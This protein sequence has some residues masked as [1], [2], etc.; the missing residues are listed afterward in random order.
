M[1]TAI[2]PHLIQLLTRL[3]GSA[4]PELDASVSALCEALEQGHVCLP[5]EKVLG[6]HQ[7]RASSVV[8][9]PG[10]LRPLI[11]D[12]VGRLYL[13]RYW[14]HENR[15][16]LDLLGRAASRPVFDDA[17][18]ES[19]IK[20]FLADGDPLQRSAVRN[21]V[22]RNFS[23]ITGGP[24]TG[25]TY[26]AT[27]ALALLAAQF[28]ASG[29]RARIVIA[30]PTGKAAARIRESLKTTL[31]KFPLSPETRALLP[32]E[33]S[34]VHRLLGSR[35]GSPDF[36]FRAGNPLN[37]DVVVIDEATMVDLPLMARLFDA[38]RPDTR[39]IL[40]GDKDQL[41]SVEAGHVLGDICGGLRDA[42]A[43]PIRESITELSRNYRF[44][45]ES[46]IHRLSRAIR[47]GNE[48]SVRALLK[49]NRP[50]LGALE[51][52]ASFAMH[53]APRVVEGFRPFLAAETASGALARFTEYRI[54]TATRNG[55]GSAEHMNRLTERALTDAGLIDPTDRNY[56]GRPIIIRRNDYSL[57]LFNGDIGIIRPDP[58]FGGS[59]RA[60]FAGED[61]ALRA[62][63][64][65]RLPEHETAFA[66][67]VHK[68]Q[69]SEF[70]RV[71]VVLPPRDVPVLSRELLY[72]AVTRARENV[73]LWWNEASLGPC[74]SRA[75]SRFSGLRDR[76]WSRVE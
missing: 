42:S 16:A 25:K 26:T 64:P 39:I 72:T 59:L 48:G 22:T 32:S 76:L 3:N 36:K 19:G 5:P 7:L 30:A 56:A 2:A 24:G 1:S 20:Q 34:T 31:E 49:V 14:D 45:D 43:S 70:R 52:S 53:L 71:L 69:G 37:A 27:V 15:L 10:D 12:A 51:I 23:V 58:E 67:T 28:S 29:T 47:S 57:R 68:S 40:L 50:D 61:G 11:L 38:L 66:M 46:N 60:F 73:E 41:A 74:L 13:Q 33:A 8:G 21:A 62:L 55:D 9:N 17:L 44:G 63:A 6:L 75:V 65:T 18:L 4:F 35:P 54:L